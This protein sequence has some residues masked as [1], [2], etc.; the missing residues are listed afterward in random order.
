M[1]RYQ[2]SSDSSEHPRTSS[3]PSNIGRGGSRITRKQRQEAQDTFQE[4][5]GSQV[6]S[7]RGPVIRRRGAMS[8]G[9]QFSSSSNSYSL[10]L[11]RLKSLSRDVMV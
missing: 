3:L 2:T 7:G 1:R 4:F 9:Y 8:G 10:N 5:G 6:R 11:Q